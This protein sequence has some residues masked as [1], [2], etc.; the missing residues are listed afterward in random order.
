MEQTLTEKCF[1]SESRIATEAAVATAHTE[2]K[3]IMNAGT[4][5]PFETILKRQEVRVF[6][7]DQTPKL[8][9]F[10]DLSYTN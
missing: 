1:E 2:T 6:F 9:F 10:L 3:E 5:P 4:A 8:L 7:C